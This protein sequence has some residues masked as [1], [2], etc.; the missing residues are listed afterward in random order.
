MERPRNVWMKILSHAR[1][2]SGIAVAAALFVFGGCSTHSAPGARVAP[3]R[4]EMAHRSP[5]QWSA[6]AGAEPVMPGGQGQTNAFPGGVMAERQR[7][8]TSGLMTRVLKRGDKVVIY[9]RDIPKPDEI[10]AELDANGGVNLPLIGTIQIEGKTTTQ[11]TDLIQKAYVAGGFYRK[12]SVIVTVEEDEYFVMGEVKREGR[13]PLSRD[14]TLLQAI[15]TAGGYTDYAKKVK[16]EIIRGRNV[17]VYNC[18]RIEERK[19]Q[20]PL[21]QPGDVVRVP[22]TIFAGSL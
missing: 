10:K 16:V 7:E 3:Y 18:D 11:A 4:P 20:D 21:I 8:G 17:N 13:Y 15:V 1:R 19:D 2:L 22:R 5:W 6:E 9:L 12:I 14:L